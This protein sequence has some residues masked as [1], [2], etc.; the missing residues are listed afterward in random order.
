[1]QIWAAEIFIQNLPDETR[2]KLLALQGTPPPIYG[3]KR[4]GFEEIFVLVT[5][6]QFVVYGVGDSIEPMLNFFLQDPTIYQHVHFYKSTEAS[7]NHLFATATGLCSDLKGVRRVNEKVRQAH[8]DAL[9]CGGMGLILD[10]LVRRSMRVSKKIRTSTGIENLGDVLIDAGMDIVFNQVDNPLE[11]SYLVLGT[12]D[13]ARSALEF[14]YNEGFRNVVIAS[15]DEDATREL[16]ERF[17]VSAIDTGQIATFIQLSD[18][19]ITEDS[20]VHVYSESSDRTFLPDRQK[21]FLD[22]GN[23]FSGDDIRHHPLCRYYT[24]EDI[25]NSPAANANVFHALEAAWQKVETEARLAIDALNSLRCVP[26]LRAHWKHIVI[27]GEQE[28][29]LLNDFA[30]SQRR[31]LDLMHY[32]NNALLRKAEPDLP[33]LLLSD[34]RLIRP[35]PEVANPS[36]C[37]KLTA[38]YCDHLN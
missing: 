38:G 31:N 36:F 7:I 27:R 22:F 17:S 15:D 10:S 16:A 28:I 11:L 4:R 29:S 25:N 21:I 24:I 32:C 33:G 18:V 9:Q 3:M 26:F 23:S 5:D 6:S 20:K 8:Y 13:I 19:V 12:G 1:M 34:F 2:K 37:K 14:F 35:G 30:K